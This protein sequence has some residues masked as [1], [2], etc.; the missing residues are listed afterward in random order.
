MPSLTIQNFMYVVNVYFH[1][2]LMVS[3]PIHNE[4]KQGNYSQLCFNKMEE[5]CQ[6]NSFNNNPIAGWI[7]H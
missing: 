2:Y 1:G 6:G 4:I 7:I 5:N 3:Q